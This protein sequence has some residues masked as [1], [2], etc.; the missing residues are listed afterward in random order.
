M[1]TM[2]IRSILLGAA[3]GACALQA[4]IPASHVAESKQRYATV[5]DNIHRAAEAMPEESYSFKPTPEIRSF[6][7]LMAHIA[8]AQ[9]NICGAATGKPK[10]AGAA[11]KTSKADIVAALKESSSHCDAAFADMTEATSGG[12]AGMGNL[13][14]SR[15]G[16]LE[17]NTGHDLEEYGY[18][19]VYMR[20]KGVVPPTSAGRGR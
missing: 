16:I 11:K 18:A 3:L 19:A 12:Q 8:D 4:Q 6:G 1:K 10:P 14:G 20:L 13:K 17:Y 2:T 9:A 7:E 15:L 5:R